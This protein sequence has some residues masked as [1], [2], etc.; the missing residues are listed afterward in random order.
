MSL[1]P[2]LQTP[3]YSSTGIPTE[4]GGA[5]PFLLFSH[6]SKYLAMRRK[7]D[8]V[9]YE[10]P[11]MAVVEE[12]KP[13]G[14]ANPA[15]RT[16]TPLNYPLEMFQWSP[17]ANMLSLWIP[18]SGD[19]P[20]RLLLVDMPSREEVASKN[21]FNVKN[22]SMH[23]QPRGDFLAL[24]AVIARKKGKKTKTETTQIEVFKVRE[25]SIPVDTVSVEGAS[26]RNLFWEQGP[27]A[28]RFATLNVDDLTNTQTLK[29]YQVPAR[30]SKKDTELVASLPLPHVVD[31][32]EWSPAGQYFVAASKGSDG[33]LMFGCINEQN[34]IEVFHKDEH[35]DLTD[36]LWDPSGR[37][38]T[39]AVLANSYRTS[40]NAGFRIYSFLGRLQYRLSNDKCVQFLWRPRPSSLLPPDKIEDVLRKIREYSKK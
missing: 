21:V 24:R 2:S 7:N 10:L 17:S 29:I 22:V 39:T 34:K 31:C 1:S 6:D 4:E 28:G 23:W 25:K 40:N 20:G 37:Y 16:R 32:F 3:Q 5:W 14:A 26:V 9:V 8:L 19:A 33:L 36:I 11:S 15:K 12:P 13:A 38:V 30:G 35:L 27:I 18:E